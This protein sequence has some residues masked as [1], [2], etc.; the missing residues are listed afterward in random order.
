MKKTILP[1]I[2]CLAVSLGLLPILKAGN[3]N[4]ATVAAAIS[5]AL[6]ADSSAAVVDAGL[7][8]SARLYRQFGLEAMG[9]SESAFQYA[10]K[11]FQQLVNNGTLNEQVLTIVDFSQPSSQKRMYILDMATGE[12]LFNTYVAHGRNSG[13]NYA[14]KFSNNNESLQ[15][16][17]GFYVTKGTYIGKHG[18]SLRLS[19]LEDGWNSNAEARAV[20]MH[21]AEYIGSG[22]AD[23][24]YMGR[25]WGCPAVPQAQ[26][27]KVINL[28]KDGT[29]LFVYH[30][31]QK[32]LESSKIING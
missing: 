1:I 12:V 25:S 2:L 31:T 27:S 32:Y 28:I 15:S 4:G 23:A 24:A 9:L 10:Y 3:R 6:P 21:G 14:E 30:P 11:G 17:L 18:L 8:A 7:A 5:T 29:A 19:G 13:L 22:R 16:S 26:A 20:V